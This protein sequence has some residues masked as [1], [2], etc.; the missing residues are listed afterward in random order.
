MT[1]LQDTT[2]LSP[3]P[4]QAAG[5]TALSDAPAGEYWVARVVRRMEG[6]SPSRIDSVIQ[7]NLPQREIRW[8]LRPDTLDIPGLQGRLP[9][10]VSSLRWDTAP[11]FFSDSTLLH[12]EY[13]P[14]QYGVVPS[15]LMQSHL[16]HDILPGTVILCFVLLSILVNTTRRFMQT[17][18]KDFFYTANTAEPTQND[19]N[20]PSTA[21][22]L[23]SCLLLC[24][25]GSL[26]AMYY[27]QSVR[28]LF[29]CT[30]P[31]YTLMGIYAALL[32]L[33]FLVRKTLSA[34]INWIFFDKGRRRLWRQDYNFLLLAEGAVLLP[35]V[36]AG[37]CFG[38]PARAVLWAGLTIV[39][40]AKLLLL[41]KTYAVFLPNFY[42]FLHLLSY[43]CALEI[44]PFLAL[45]VALHGITDNLTITF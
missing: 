1:A 44:L 11:C 32:A 2:A 36:A 38:M 39:A 16:L 35:V 25:T 17:R 34:F 22:T 7:A 21:A 19:K 27:V 45:W 9:Y 43:L 14:H 30:V 29:L 24:A 4:Q 13:T 8:S 5:D 31:A 23:M 3:Q 26:Y 6:C 15:R 20:V 28:D 42:C 10:S 37:I 18:A 12:T 41:Y 40:G 33:M